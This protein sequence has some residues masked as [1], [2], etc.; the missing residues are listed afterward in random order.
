MSMWDA[1]EL[2]RD[3]LRVRAGDYSP[4]AKWSDRFR[5]FADSV[6][7]SGNQNGTPTPR[8]GAA[9]APEKSARRR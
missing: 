3:L 4:V 9:M 6:V 8:N 5:A 1:D 2:D 7:A